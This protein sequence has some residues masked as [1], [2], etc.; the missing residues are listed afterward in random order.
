M[1]GG[2][3]IKRALPRG[4]GPAVPLVYPLTVNNFADGNVR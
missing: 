3:T 2:A 4:Q 1:Q